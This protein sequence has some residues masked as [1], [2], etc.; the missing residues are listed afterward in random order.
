MNSSIEQ[1]T[2]ANNEFINFNNINSVLSQYVFSSPVSAYGALSPIGST[3]TLAL[4]IDSSGNSY[5]EYFDLN[6]NPHGYVYS[7]SKFYTF[8]E[9][10]AP[11]VSGYGTTVNTNFDG[12]T[13]IVAGNYQDRLGISHGY[14]YSPTS[15]YVSINHP[16]ASYGTYINTSQNNNILSGFYVGSDAKTHGFVY[17]ALLGY[18]SLDA[19]SG[20]NGSGVMGISSDGRITGFYYD[21]SNQKHG[22]SWINNQFSSLNEPVGAVNVVPESINKFGEIVGAYQDANKVWHGFATSTVTGNTATFDYPSG[23]LTSLTGINDSHDVIGVATTATGSNVSF[24]TH[25]TL[26]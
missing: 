13:D 16:Q 22:Y 3:M 5:G 7:N 24:L 2:L 6:Y 25:L 19:P 14:F 1:N 21:S 18:F 15:G 23:S 9:P 26:V 11:Y 12:S 10:S 8:N 17:V 20:V 4:G